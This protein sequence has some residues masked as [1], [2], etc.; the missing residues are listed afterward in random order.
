MKRYLITIVVIGSM[1]VCGSM[2]VVNGQNL[3]NKALD[4]YE[5]S[6]YDLALVYYKQLLTVRPRDEVYLHHAA[7]C[8][9]Q[10]R[11]YEQAISTWTKLLSINPEHIDGMS[12]LVYCLRILQRHSEA[13]SWLKKLANHDQKAAEH[14]IKSCEFA[15]ADYEE[16]SLYH[17]EIAPFNSDHAT[18]FVSKILN[19]L[20]GAT[21]ERPSNADR[22]NHPGPD[23]HIEGENS[24][25]RMTL[26]ESKK[27]FFNSRLTYSKNTGPV[28]F[29]RSTGLIA[30]A[31]NNFS[32]GV[33]QV[34]QAAA[35]QQI[36]FAY[37]D[38]KGEWIEHSSFEYNSSEYAVGYPFLTD[39]GGTLYFASN[40]PGGYGGFDI[41]VSY[42]VDS[43]WTKP[44]NLG[45]RINTPGDEISPFFDGSHLYFSSDFHMGYGG[46]DIFRADFNYESWTNP[47]NLGPLVNS[48]FDDFNFAF[49]ES[50]NRGYFCSDRPSS[51]KN[52]NIYRVGKN[53]KKIK[54]SINDFKRQVPITGVE[55]DLSRCGKPVGIT[56]AAG[57]FEFEISQGFDC[58]V[59]LAKVGYTGTSF[60]LKYEDISGPIKKFNIQLNS[61][62]NFYQGQVVSKEANEGIKGVYVSLINELDGEIQE[63]YTDLNGYYTFYIKP[64][65]RYHISFAKT[66]YLPSHLDFKTGSKMSENILGRIQLAKADNIMLA[67]F[68]QKDSPGENNGSDTHLRQDA[69]AQDVE[70]AMKNLH[71]QQMAPLPAQNK[72]QLQEV[73]ALPPN[74]IEEKIEASTAS[75]PIY[76]SPASVPVKKAQPPSAIRIEDYKENVNQ[77]AIL[78]YAIQIAAFANPNID[79]TPFNY[80]LKTFGQVYMSQRSDGLIRIMV[81]IYDTKLEAEDILQR[82]RADKFKEAFITPIPVGV[83]LDSPEAFK[84]KHKNY[85][86]PMKT[87]ISESQE[88]YMVNIGYFKHMRWFDNKEI[89]EIG[90]I[91]ER[92]E[93]DKIL[94]LLS[95]YTSK[96]EALEALEKVQSKGYRNANVVKAG[97]NGELIPVN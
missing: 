58:Y 93:K 53:A 63:T 65:G 72:G 13:T 91:E 6:R 75:A 44:Q 14:F 95:G 68:Y 50:I 23:N 17:I 33:R 31:V 40:M 78:G 4:L 34:A 81:G 49:F 1:A 62:V 52:E 74:E 11:Q 30:Y 70:T 77:P 96:A 76:D 5:S 85:P 16:S 28:A 7:M 39:D 67:E 47:I 15:Y 61:T 35:G 79:I 22:Q 60:R 32:E 54:I 48:S 21:T 86:K 41:Y 8:F 36:R 24:L 42:F 69:L 9:L 59:S 46:L 80:Y 26:S 51:F 19:D 87:S 38:D 12:H 66:G 92:R 29:A 71:N 84:R 37:L 3:T 57:Q 64:M 56:N 83:K 10:T 89:E 25:F 97:P 82:I 88:E 20:I 27:R 55:I 90:L 45:P 2:S 73:D 18:F 94:V 43:T